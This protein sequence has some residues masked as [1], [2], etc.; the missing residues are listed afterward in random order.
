MKK[1]LSL[2]FIIILS[3][4]S[5][6]KKNDNIKHPKKVQLKKVTKNK[7]K[8]TEVDFFKILSDS[9]KLY[10]L[11]P[12]DTLNVEFNYK[13]LEKYK[14]SKNEIQIFKKDSFN[15]DWIKINSKKIIVDNLTTINSRTDGDYDEM[16]CNS[17]EKI[18]YYNYKNNKIIMMI[19]T[20]HPCTG[21]GCSVTD[22]LI[23]NIDKEQINLFG[24]FRSADLELYDFHMNSKINYIAT[25]FN[26]DFHG[27]TPISSKSRLYSMKKNGRFE[28]AKDKNNKEYYFETTYP[29]DTSKDWT[30]NKNWFKFK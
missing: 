4:C 6:E 27:A 18:K 21:L 13:Q 3:S 28:L 15:I 22:Y 8:E 26:G 17:L 12:I 14:I 23:Y 10:K 5:N 16:F 29:N 2:I 24:N 30:F 20:S 25:E 7:L 11:K 9:I 19:F 1:I